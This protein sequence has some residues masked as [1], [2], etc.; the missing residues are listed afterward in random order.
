MGAPDI[1]IWLIDYLKRKFRGRTVRSNY[2]KDSCRMRYENRHIQVS[3]SGLE[4]EVGKI[5]YEYDGDKV[6]F[7]IEYEYQ[8]AEF[9]EFRRLLRRETAGNADIVWDTWQDHP[10]CRCGFIDYSIESEEDL[11]S[12]FEALMSVFDNL[13]SR[14]LNEAPSVEKLLSCPVYPS[15]VL[16]VDGKISSATPSE[17]DGVGFVAATLADLFDCNLSIPPY[18]RDYCWDDEDISRL[19][20]SLA[21]TGGDV[22]LGN[23]ILQQNEDRFEIIDGQQRLITLTLIAMALRWQR[24]LSLARARVSSRASINNIANAKSV[25]SGL[26]RKGD[27]GV[28]GLFEDC[29]AIHIGALILGPETDIDLA[30]TF[31]ASHNSKG[32]PL[33]DFDL[34]KAHHLQFVPD[35]DRASSLASAWDTMASGVPDPDSGRRLRIL[36]GYHLLNLRKWMRYDVVQDTQ[37]AVRNEFVEAPRLTSIAVDADNACEV[38]SGFYDKICGGEG[39]FRYVGRMYDRYRAFLGTETMSVFS[40][41]LCHSS[42]I[43]YHLAIEALLFGYYLK[44]GDRYL[45]EALFCISSVVAADRYS[46]SQMRQSRLILSVRDSRVIMMIDQATEPAF[47]LAEALR[48]I[49]VD[50]LSMAEE[51]LSGIRRNF[52]IGLQ[53]VFRKLLPRVAEESIRIKILDIYE[54]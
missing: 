14:A 28:A 52:Y 31:F 54:L 39:F 48:A 1:K 44:F 25:V 38:D 42:H 40:E 36:M 3:V 22:Y 49:T 26:V 35:E 47:F 43:H 15:A 21:E 4:G 27:R 46:H 53:S 32:L 10:A 13:V 2:K 33:S 37:H 19:W 50:P 51:D 6:W 30:Y 24:P 41:E 12:A 18:Q 16:P 20:A 9:R 23:V 11:V 5:H 45:P 29:S 34:L 7:H 17:P 8:G